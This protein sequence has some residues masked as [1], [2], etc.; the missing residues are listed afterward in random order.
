[1]T[2]R[3]PMPTDYR[4]SHEWV[5]PSVSAARAMFPNQGLHPNAEFIA[6][7]HPRAVEY[8]E[9][10]P[11]LA[12][13]MG[14]K[15]ATRADRLYMASR[16]GGP[17]ER[18][19]RLR[20]VM[21][22]VGLPQPLRQLRPFALSP[23]IRAIVMQLATIPPSPLALMI[24]DKPGKQR[25]WLRNLHSWNG[26][27][28]RRTAPNPYFA[29][30]ARELARHDPRPNEVTTA[31]DFLISNAAVWNDRWSWDR[32]MVE[33]ELWHDRLASEKNLLN[34]GG[35]ITAETVIDYSDWPAEQVVGAF[36]FVKLDT[37]V[38]IF[39]EGRR[40]RHCVAS[41][42]ADVINGSCT[43]YS[44]RLGDRRMATL[45]LVD[46]AARQLAGF[47]NSS[48]PKGVRAAVAAFLDAHPFA[49]PLEPPH[50]TRK[51]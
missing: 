3:V 28:S 31:G 17:I 49:P 40:M 44:I 25:A 19:E 21:A 18:G 38:A 37:P 10:A 5:E 34:I 48:P 29:W 24:P 41:Y 9:Q 1:M 11:V 36:K 8:L 27:F 16:L 45:E 4:L 20:S 39:N 15:R 13:A 42:M 6:A 2:G 22:S 7:L 35:G 30:A 23:G 47:A 43:L 46:G 50:N 33:A 12:C 26:L 32:V 51:G 14:A